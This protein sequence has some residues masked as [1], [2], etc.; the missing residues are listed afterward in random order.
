MIKFVE[1]DDAIVQEVIVQDCYG[2]RNL[3]P[4][5]ECVVDGGAC[6]GAFSLNAFSCGAQYVLAYEPDPRA[7]K[8]LEANV[9]ANHALDVVWMFKAAL[10]FACGERQLVTS[11]DVGQS[12]FGPHAGVTV[13]VTG[14]PAASNR[15]QR[16]LLKLDVE[17][18]ERELF[19]RSNLE[20]I[21]TYTDVVMEWHNYD[22][23]LYASI[24]HQLGFTITYLAGGDGTPWN[25]TLA[26]GILRASTRAGRGP[27]VV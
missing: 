2:L 6:F 25:P 7:F 26:G 23:E 4:F 11:G 14:L 19:S 12:H 16:A 5:P 9:E 17:G 21:R 22:G 18:A 20:T 24:L 27:V 1:K 10:G 8:M 13:P 15:W 3:T